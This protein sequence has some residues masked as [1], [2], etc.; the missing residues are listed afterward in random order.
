MCR[1]SDHLLVEGGGVE[2][3][4]TVLV[5]LPGAVEDAAQRHLV[6]G[7]EEGPELAASTRPRADVQ[8]ALRILLQSGHAPGEVEREPVVQFSGIR[9]GARTWLVDG[10]EHTPPVGGDG[11]PGPLLDHRVQVAGLLGGQCPTSH[12]PWPAVLQHDLRHVRREELEADREFLAGLA[13]VLGTAAVH[14]PA[15]PVVGLREQRQAYDGGGPFQQLVQDMIGSALGL[16]VQMSGHPQHGSIELRAVA[17]CHAG[18]GLDLLVRPGSVESETS[19]AAEEFRCV[20]H[21]ENRF[22]AHSETPDLASTLLRHTHSKNCLRAVRSHRVALVCAVQVGLRE[23]DINSPVLLVD[24]FVGRI[25]DEL[26][27]LAVAI[28]ALSDTTLAIGVFGHEAGV[29]GICLQDARG[30]FENGLNYRRG[31]RRHCFCAPE[32]QR[33]GR[34]GERRAGRRTGPC[35]VVALGVN[36]HSAFVKRRVHGEIV[37]CCQTETSGP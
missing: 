13:M 33:C 29:H 4:L 20:G 14:V 31:R 6:L 5:R 24:H 21:H 18:H 35:L 22:K 17:R 27:K 11:L 1:R 26:E 2:E 10:G 36:F 25:L 7:R 8:T 15:Q 32:C 3:I 34:K 23:D 37:G 12:G 28:P 30:L 16:H 19:R 9:A